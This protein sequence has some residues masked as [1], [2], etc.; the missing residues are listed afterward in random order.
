VTTEPTTVRRRQPEPFGVEE[1][2][3][4][5]LPVHPGPTTETAPD[6]DASPA[7]EPADA[8]DAT[9]AGDAREWTA[10]SPWD[11]RDYRI[12]AVGEGVS[13]LGDAV[14]FTALPLLV[15]ALTGSGTIMGVVAALQTLPDLVIGLPAGALADR[16][17]RRRMM[18]WADLGRALL[19]ALIPLAALLGAPTIVV[20]LLVVAPINALRVL[21][22]AAW[23]GAIPRLVGR[24]LIGPGSSYLEAIFSL[25][26]IVGPGLAGLLVSRIG[27]AATLAIDAA[28]FLVSAAALLLVRTPLHGERTD[29]SGRD[30]LGEIREGLRFVRDHPLL[31]AALAYWGAIGILTA[32]LIPALTYL[33]E[34]ERG[35]GPDSFGL[36]IS[37]YSLGTLLG[38][39][40]AARLTRGRL[41]VLLVGGGLVVGGVIFAIAFV[42]PTDW[43]AGLSLVGG[44]AN[45]LV[46][47]SYVTIRA[48]SAPDELLGRVGATTRMISVGL[49]PLGAAIAGILLDA[50]GGE[51]T[52]ELMA[53]GLIVSA[54]AAGLSPTLRAARAPGRAVATEPTGAV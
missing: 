14:T 15:L 43:V 7:R 35:Q 44:V 48:S 29:D 13:A 41:G 9:R 24:S 37:A 42:V 6:R 34:R 2:L 38:A 40:G 36:V 51:L 11:L 3:A 49:S 47:V 4:A 16:W 17:D 10:S 26:F 33:I 18:I 31:R 12:I 1:E 20:I 21:F 19:T 8:I 25:G 52:L 28:S 5:G 39:L 54:V 46:L 50:V 30:L 32:G 53:L 22:M 23:T 45:S 27:G